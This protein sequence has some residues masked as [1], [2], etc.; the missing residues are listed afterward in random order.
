L[1]ITAPATVPIKLPI[2]EPRKAPCRPPLPSPSKPPIVPPTLLPI[3]APVITAPA[4]CVVAQLV[5]S[6]ANTDKVNSSFLIVRNCFVFV[7][8]INKFFLFI[9]VHLHY[10]LYFCGNKTDYPFFSQ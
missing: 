7:A 6:N 8:K 10:Y 9:I 1:A 3:A 5:Q 2:D 4:F